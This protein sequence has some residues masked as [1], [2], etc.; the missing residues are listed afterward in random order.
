MTKNCWVIEKRPFGED[1]PEKAA[2][3]FIPQAD[4]VAIIGTA[5]INH[6]MEMLLSLCPT[7]A[8][9]MILGPSTPLTPLLFNAG[10][11]FLSGARVFD[12]QAAVNTIQQGAIFRQVQGVRL[13]TMTLEYLSA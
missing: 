2:A 12:E 10:I 3:E 11:S 9:V 1:F 6:S 13:L 5:F 8:Q 7:Q 4:V